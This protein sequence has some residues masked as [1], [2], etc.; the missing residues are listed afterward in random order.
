MADTETKYL[1]PIENPD[2]V[3]RAIINDEDDFL[4]P[5]GGEPRVYSDPPLQYI[6]SEI[7]KFGKEFVLDTAKGLTPFLTIGLLAVIKA[8]IDGTAFMAGQSNILLIVVLSGLLGAYTLLNAKVQNSETE[9]QRSSQ[10]VKEGRL[11]Q[12]QETLAKHHQNKALAFVQTER[13]EA[14]LKTRFIEQ[15]S[16]DV[17]KASKRASAALMVLTSASLL[18]E[19]SR[20]EIGVGHLQSLFALGLAA[21]Y[22]SFILQARIH[23]RYKKRLMRHF[24]GQRPN[25]A[26]GEYKELAELDA[27]SAISQPPDQQSI[28]LSTETEFDANSYYAVNPAKAK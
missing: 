9:D 23:D 18:V 5:Y 2:A 27:M 25:E 19:S 24:L 13:L 17:L 12:L 8:E 7:V 14:K 15:K 3:A 20:T 1:N 10:N 26:V 11:H 6:S 16:E 22:Y 21:W 28:E 4:W